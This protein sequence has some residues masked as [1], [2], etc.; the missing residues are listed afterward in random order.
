MILE[1]ELPDKEFLIKALGALNLKI[2]E[3]KG[4][5]D[6]ETTNID[7][8]AKLIISLK[9]KVK[10]MAPMELYERVLTIICEMKKLYER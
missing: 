2:L 10:V 9:D 6:F 4:I 8:V 3:N 5:I 1:F 7:Y